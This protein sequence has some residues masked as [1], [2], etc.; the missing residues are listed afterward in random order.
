MYD[1][2]IPTTAEIERLTRQAHAMRAEAIRSAVHGFGR[3]ISNAFHRLFA[4]HAH[5]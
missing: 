2:Q 3:T 4:R 5:G 1:Y